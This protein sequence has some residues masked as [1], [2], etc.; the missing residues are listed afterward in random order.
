[1]SKFGDVIKKLNARLEVMERRG[2]TGTWEYQQLRNRISA[3]ASKNMTINSN[4]YTH[5]SGRG[6]T[7]EQKKY[8]TTLSNNTR[9]TATS[10]ENRLL[11]GAR[12]AGITTPRRIAIAQFGRMERDIHEFI[13]THKEDIY[14]I[15]YFH[16]M[17]KS[18][19]PLTLGQAHELLTMYSGPLWAA[20]FNK[21]KIKDWTKGRK[22]SADMSYKLDI[23]DDLMQE[24][25]KLGE[26]I[27]WDFNLSM[28]IV[29]LQQDI[30]KELL[31]N[32]L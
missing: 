13:A 5:I 17:I 15:S 2:L 14:K 11:Q 26:S 28:R 9:L 21:N 1:M 25:D 23:L 10:A 4:G 24:Q 20:E 12:N 3:I 7:A 18:G 8:L 29:K 19:K 32:D 22:L 6:M 16:S 31:K 30:Q 27:K